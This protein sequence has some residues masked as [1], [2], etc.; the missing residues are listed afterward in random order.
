MNSG[1]YTSWASVYPVHYSSSFF[2]LFLKFFFLEYIL[3][4]SFPPSP[5]SSA[6]HSP[7]SPRCT[8][9]LFLPGTSS[10]FFGGWVPYSFC[11][12]QMHSVFEDDLEFLV[13]SVQKIEPRALGMLG[14]WSKSLSNTSRPWVNSKS[15]GISKNRHWENLIW[16]LRFSLTGMIWGKLCTFSESQLS[17]EKYKSW[18]L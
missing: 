9:P 8:P 1:W 18:W 6:P 4:T 16:I 13:Y 11:W 10:F 17:H 5:R 15:H 12:S 7:L 14:P 3:T 2:H